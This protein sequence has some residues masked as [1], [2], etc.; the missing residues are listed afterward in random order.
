MKFSLLSVLVAV[1]L[2]DV[3]CVAASAAIV[4]VSTKDETSDGPAAAAAIVE[5]TTRDETSDGPAAA[6]AI[7]EVTTR[8]E[9]SDDGP[10][11]PPR[12]TLVSKKNPTAAAVATP[13]PPT[14]KLLFVQAGTDCALTPSATSGEYLFRATVGEATTYFSER[15]D[16][17]AGTMD[18]E[19][20]AEQFGDNFF[21]TS[22]P[23]G[24]ITFFGDEN[25][26][27]PL[28]AVLSRPRMVSSS[29]SIIEY[30][31]TQSDSQGEVASIEQFM[32][33]SG[34]CSIFIDAD[35]NKCLP[36]KGQWPAGAL[37]SAGNTFNNVP[38]ITC[39]SFQR[40]E[41]YCWSHTYYRDAFWQSCTPKGFT[42]SDDEGWSVAT[43]NSNDDEW[44]FA[45]CGL[46]CQEFSSGM[47]V[48]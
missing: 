26:T 37:S 41:N 40:G 13:P 31:M 21:V 24:A 32:G 2:F 19:V 15:P 46:G 27:G 10:G 45:A 29:S 33:M 30:T 42:D 4:E 36:A 11:R 14:P 39:F 12:R 8:D 16:R 25:N 1:F 17:L 3:A 28:I 47:P 44:N 5:V 35:D 38:F 7:D 34:S 22:N 6:A 43:G 48:P 20:F 18:T 23:N 9:T